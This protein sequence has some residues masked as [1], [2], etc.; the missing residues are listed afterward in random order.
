MLSVIVVSV[1]SQE[2]VLRAPTLL[3]GVCVAEKPGNPVGAQMA[4]FAYKD[5][6]FFTRS[7]FEYL[8]LYSS[9]KPATI[10]M[11]KSSLNLLSPISNASPITTTIDPT[12]VNDQNHNVIESKKASKQSSSLIEVGLQ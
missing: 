9:I 8:R 3:L 7:P 4:R 6:V 12:N 10:S 2:S 5:L 11:I 1:Q